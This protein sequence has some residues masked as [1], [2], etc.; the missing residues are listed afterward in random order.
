MNWS[1][2][3]A[4]SNIPWQ[5]C[6]C[7]QCPIPTEPPAHPC[8]DTMPI[9]THHAHGCCSVQGQRSPPT[10]GVPRWGSPAPQHTVGAVWVPA[11][12]W[13]HG[14]QE[15]RKAN[16][17]SKLHISGFWFPFLLLAVS[18]ET[19]VGPGKIRLGFAAEAHCQPARLC[20]PPASLPHQGNAW[21]PP[22]P[23]PMW[24]SALGAELH[25]HPLASSS[26]LHPSTW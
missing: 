19:G 7:L 15:S 16:W 12:S 23:A 10:P 25:Q 22:T 18:M 6:P 5:Q 8:W 24:C 13:G 14:E 21:V 1:V 2:H 9:P 20:A 11:P 4:A 26:T 3:G 17:S